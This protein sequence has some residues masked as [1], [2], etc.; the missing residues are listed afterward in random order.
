MT[1]IEQKPEHVN[2]VLISGAYILGFFQKN[3]IKN[4]DDQ[5]FLITYFLDVCNF[6]DDLATDKEMGMAENTDFQ[7]LNHIFDALSEVREVIVNNTK[8]VDLEELDKYLEP[9]KT[10]SLVYDDIKSVEI[11]K[12]ARIASCYRAVAAVIGT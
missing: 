12:L 5:E 4:F 10:L 8:G 3:H 6:F 2:K 9:L 11:D 7:K 1:D